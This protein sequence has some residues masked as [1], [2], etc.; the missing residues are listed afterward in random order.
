MIPTLVATSAAPM[1]M[2]VAADSPRPT[3]SAIPPPSGSAKPSA[4]TSAAVAP[5]SASSDA[6]VSSP[7]QKRRKT[8]PS[9]AN[10]SRVSVGSDEAEHGR[11]EH[12]A[13]EDLADDRRLAESLEE[14]VAELG[15]EEDDEEVDERAGDGAVARGGEDHDS[16][17]RAQHRD[18]E[19]GARQ[20]ADEAVV[21][22]DRQRP[23]LAVEEPLGRVGGAR[24]QLERVRLA[25]VLGHR[26]VDDLLRP[27]DERVRIV[28]D[29]GR[30]AGGRR[31]SAGKSPRRRSTSVNRP[32][33][34][35]SA[36]TTAIAGSRL[37]RSAAAASPKVAVLADRSRAQ[38]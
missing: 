27:L 21:V 32:T 1:K 38:G 31:G 15:G 25:H 37:S 23:L 26:L 11:A 8:T 24:V 6:F 30:C 36:S 16:S 22:L 18:R 7:T 17:L 34:R 14:L 2:L 28:R 19:L 35:A 4:P 10:T 5:T 12:D 20:H 13:G 33:T 9:S 29:E 3:P